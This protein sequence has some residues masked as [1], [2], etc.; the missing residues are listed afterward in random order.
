MLIEST[1]WTLFNLNNNDYQSQEAICYA[2]E[3]PVWGEDTEETDEDKCLPKAGKALLLSQ[4]RG[5]G[6]V[7]S[8]VGDAR[9]SER[10]GRLGVAASQQLSPTTTSNNKLKI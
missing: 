7:P 5:Q 4:V 2:R 9:E 8:V 6:S 10:E 3:I 1:V